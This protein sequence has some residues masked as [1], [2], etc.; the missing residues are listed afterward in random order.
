MTK[1]HHVLEL[2]K[3]VFDPLKLNRG[4]VIQNRGV[5]T[6][7]KPYTRGVSEQLV[8]NHKKSTNHTIVCDWFEQTL[9][10]LKTDW[11]E[12][13]TE[14]APSIF[15]E[16]HEVGTKHYER[17]Y[18]LYLYGQKFGQLLTTPR[19]SYVPKDRVQFK[20]FNHLLYTSGW[21][22]DYKYILS[23]LGWEWVSTTRLD[24]AI[25]NVPKLI[26]LATRST[27][28]KVIKR[29]GKAAFNVSYGS[30]N[31]ITKIEF[32]SLRSDKHAKGY[33]KGNELDSSG[34]TYI[35]DY[36]RN[37]GLKVPQSEADKLWRY[38][39]T[40]KPKINSQY[41][42]QRFDDP[43]YL[44][45]IV[46]TESKNWCA[47][48]YDGKDK[49]KHRKYQ[50]S[51]MEYINWTEIGGCLLEKRKRIKMESNY[52]AKQTVKT[53]TENLYKGISNDYCRIDKGRLETSYQDI[54]NQMIAE[55]QIQNWY[56]DRLP[57]WL[58][59]WDKEIQFK[60]KLR[61]MTP[62]KN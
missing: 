35:E 20:V 32:G 21:L 5:K 10:T 38:E 24:I 41:D 23:E 46:R 18:T 61:E 26:E 62:S 7:P 49:N 17:T 57:N 56:D 45:S 52:K 22:D 16:P 33:P 37:N 48:Y 30:Q 19:R 15:L 28:S 13:D 43:Q 6:P 44:A 3:E 59:D 2:P 50:A 1:L 51:T 58:I 39:M 34:K 27:K 12:V 11:Q 4:Q 31:E 60:E 25:D 40:L 29:K 42:W 8:K 36:W 54:I 47:F 55:H 53:L 9:S 14:L